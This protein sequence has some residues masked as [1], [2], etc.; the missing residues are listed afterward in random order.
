MVLKC[1]KLVSDQ[2][3]EA[4]DCGTV[5]NLKRVKLQIWLVSPKAGLGD[6]QFSAKNLFFQTESDSTAKVW[7]LFVC[8]I[9][10]ITCMLT[11]GLTY[12]FRVGA[13][14]KEWSPSKFSS[15]LLTRFITPC[16]LSTC[17]PPQVKS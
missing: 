9:L 8:L 12:V 10:C 7:S 1:L 6:Q 4:G 2:A 11:V 13:E 14:A 3:R 15:V 17:L 5:R 16:R